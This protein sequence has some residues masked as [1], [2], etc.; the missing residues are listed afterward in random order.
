MSFV[1]PNVTHVYAGAKR[2]YTVTVEAR[3][4]TSTRNMSQTVHVQERLTGMQ[5]EID[6]KKKH[7]KAFY[8][9]LKAASLPAG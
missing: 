5:T 4:S 9:R 7:Q 1:G 8:N 3:N 6:L 2:E